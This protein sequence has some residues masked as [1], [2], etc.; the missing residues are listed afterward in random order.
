MFTLA[1]AARFL[2]H[3]TTVRAAFGS[4]TPR[5]IEEIAR[6]YERAADYLH[7]RF[8]RKERHERDSD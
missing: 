7:Q 8:N 5:P 3:A 1:T 2:R 4:P 6:R